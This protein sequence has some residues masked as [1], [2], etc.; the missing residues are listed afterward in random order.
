MCF[1]HFEI[2]YQEMRLQM[3]VWVKIIWINIAHTYGKF[4]FP[5][6]PLVSCNPQYGTWRIAM[7][8][9][10]WWVA[11]L[12]IIVSS[13]LWCGEG[14]GEMIVDVGVITSPH[15]F[16]SWDDKNKNNSNKIKVTLHLACIIQLITIKSKCMWQE[17]AQG[18]LWLSLKLSKAVFNFQNGKTN[19]NFRGVTIN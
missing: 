13:K 9:N 12:G 5:C 4:Q 6:F 19:T 17:H 7:H 11:V 10:F 3:Y 8:N 16:C 15:F 14:V 2:E 18:S 1:S